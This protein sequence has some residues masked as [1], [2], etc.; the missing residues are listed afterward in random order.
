MATKLDTLTP[1]MDSFKDFIFRSWIQIFKKMAKN[2]KKKVNIFFGISKRR[3][4][5]IE[6]TLESHRKV[7]EF[8]E[9]G[10]VKVTVLEKSWKLV[11]IKDFISG[12]YNKIKF[13]QSV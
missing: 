11:W 6:K 1:E 9:F 12:F 13:L 8:T 3:A 5:N 2:G 4:K 10:S 7:Q